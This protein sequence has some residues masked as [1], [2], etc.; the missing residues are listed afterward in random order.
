M[1]KKIYS[2]NIRQV[3]KHKC[4][5]NVNVVKIG[6]EMR[7]Q[8]KLEIRRQLNTTIFLTYT[9]GKLNETDITHNVKLQLTKNLKTVRK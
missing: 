9:K 2:L 5:W 8:L 6:K 3:D 1:K 7:E 4:I